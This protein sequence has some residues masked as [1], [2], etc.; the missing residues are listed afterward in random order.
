[1]PKWLKIVL[2][3]VAGIILLFVLLSVGLL[4]YINTNKGKVL[5]LI[6]STL[7]K[8]LDG[9]LT[10]GDMET[11][12][13][14]GFP[15]ISVTLKN[16]LIKDKRWPEHRHTLLDAKDFD[17]SI[18]TASLLRGTIRISNIDISNAAIDLYKDSTGY[19][20]TSVFKK[21]KQQPKTEQSDD[22]GSSAE[23]GKFT[24][25]KVS[26]AVNNQKN[27]KLFQF[28][29]N[30]LAGKMNYPDTGWRA[31]LQL[32]V[33]TKSL[34]F[35]TLKG[36]FLK[37]KTI[38]GQMIAGYNEDNGKIKVTSKN[39]TIGQDPFQINASFMTAKKETEFKILVIANEITWRN[40]SAL[41]AENIRITLDKFNLTK[42]IKINAK[43]AGSFGGGDPLLHV[44]GNIRNN[45]LSIPGGKID[46]CSFDA[47]FNNHAAANKGYDDENSTIRLFRFSGRYNH[48]PFVIDTGSIINL[49]KPI[50]TGNFQAKFPLA[51]LNYTF[52]D[53]A[54]FTRGT[55]NVK[56]RYKADVVNYRLNKPVIAGLI[57][58]KDADAV[59]LPRNLAFKNTSLSLNFIKD[60]LILNNIRLQSGHSVVTMEGRVNNFLNLYYN[61]PEKILLTWNIKSPELRLNEFLG[62]LAARRRV[63]A[64][65]APRGNSGNVVDQLSNVLDKGNAEMHMEVAKVYY[66]KFLATDVKADL[67]TTSDGVILKNVGVKHAG[68][69]LQLNGRVTQGD[70]LNRFALNTTVLNVNIREFF[71]SFSNFGLST[72]TYENLKG[73]LSAKTSITGGV[74]DKGDLVPRSI[75][76]T[77]NVSLRNGALLNYEPLIKVGKFAFPFRDLKN[78][79]IPKLD[80][81][82]DVRGEKIFIRPMQFSS[83][84]LNADIAGVYALTKGTDIA[85]DIPLRNPKKDED[86]TDKEELQKRRFKGIV[87]HLA[88]RDDENGKIKI[89]WNKDHK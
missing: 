9:K 28:Y 21:K 38:A 83:S 8:N 59:Y 4:I 35:N 77:V 87:L 63:K 23:F 1:M 43:I 70:A 29:I 15:G 69:S 18:N 65:A 11:T 30:Q 84:V 40:A 36:T 55:A 25:K 42:P 67:I 56:L 52:G 45:T 89:G 32:N 27:N 5:T 14:K 31:D 19:S 78:I 34:A 3:V 62:F 72:P 44:T 13:F 54:K 85:L 39:L 75:N 10:I 66:R 12:F 64:S 20:N 46:S 49:K 57:S 24:L 81:H 16:V 58:F 17:V 88:A 7:N 50:A 26:F 6:T 79:E 68:G 51:N 76:G 22:G 73:F 71:Q 61:A 82:F 80:A 74:T 33:L 2:K 48:L 86:I 41:L 53:V 60:D 37:D 47:E